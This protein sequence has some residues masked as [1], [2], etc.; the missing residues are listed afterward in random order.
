M[1]RA[2][3]ARTWKAR[4]KLCSS[5]HSRRA[6][7]RYRGHVRADRHHTLCFECFRAETDRLRHRIRLTTE[8]INFNIPASFVTSPGSVAAQ[9]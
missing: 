4:R 3:V 8:F 5:C 2:V 7:F 9:L 1:S 6:K